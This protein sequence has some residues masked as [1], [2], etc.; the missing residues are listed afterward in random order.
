MPIEQDP[1]VNLLRDYLATNGITQFDS[2]ISYNQGVELDRLRM[3][4]QSPE[5]FKKAV[6]E[7]EAERK[8]KEENER[9]KFLDQ[10]EAERNDRFYNNN[11]AAEQIA[12]ARGKQAQKSNLELA[13]IKQAYEDME[14]ERK[15]ARMAALEQQKR[16]QEENRRADEIIW[17]ARLEGD[18]QEERTRRP[19]YA[20]W[21]R[22]EQWLRPGRIVERRGDMPVEVKPPKPKEPDIPMAPDTKKRRIKLRD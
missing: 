14:E 15:Q 21:M 8:Q 19:I 7:W 1:K 16:K 22:E 11:K 12:L 20:E 5:Q 6:L 13:A 9:K 2:P 10:L 17:R 18:G 4:F 3:L